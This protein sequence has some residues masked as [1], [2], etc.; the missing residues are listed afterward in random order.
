MTFFT[1]FTQKL[2][3]LTVILYVV[4]T[5]TS[6]R[7]VEKKTQQH[8]TTSYFCIN[9]IT[10]R[11]KMKKKTKNGTNAN[12]KQIVNTNLANLSIFFFNEVLIPESFWDSIISNMHGQVPCT[13]QNKKKR[14]KNGI[15]YKVRKI[16]IE[17]MRLG[18]NTNYNEIKS[19]KS[20]IVKQNT[21]QKKVVYFF[22]YYLQEQQ[23]QIEYIN[24][25]IFGKNFI[26]I[27]F[28]LFNIFEYVIQVKVEHFQ[29]VNRTK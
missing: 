14:N 7:S 27:F 4:A 23:Q 6:T 9:C 10:K 16:K 18:Q 17:R 15:R 5:Q 24:G 11:R 12:C 3:L 19:S 8:Y 1:Q 25:K 13:K 29:T 22:Y 2:K 21:T 26:C 20:L 28:L